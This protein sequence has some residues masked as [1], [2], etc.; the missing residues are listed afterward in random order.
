[1]R[2]TA[3]RVIDLFNFLILCMSSL[4]SYRLRHQNLSQ[5]IAGQLYVGPTTYRRFMT[6]FHRL[7]ADKAKIRT[8]TVNKLKWVLKVF[9]AIKILLLWTFEL[10]RLCDCYCSVVNI[11]AIEISLFI[12]DVWWTPWTR[13]AKMPKQCVGTS[14]T[15]TRTMRMPRTRRPS[16]CS[17]WP[18]VPLSWR[19]LKLK[20]VAR[21]HWVPSCSSTSFLMRRKRRMTFWG[22]VSSWRGS[23]KN[24]LGSCG[25]SAGSFLGYGGLL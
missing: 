1:M 17:N 21:L 13:P 8:E 19:S 12:S 3:S 2:W 7:Y 9:P 11:C 22:K 20:L 15:S 10:R 6:T 16:C 25:A 24:P 4:P 5:P 18:P 14:K 23:C